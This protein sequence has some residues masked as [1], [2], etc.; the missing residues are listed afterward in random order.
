MNIRSI[1]LNVDPDNVDSSSFRYAVDLAG[2]FGAE[3]IG[4]AAEYPALPT[5]FGPDGGAVSYEIYENERQDISRRLEAAGARFRS[6]APS[7]LNP[8]WRAYLA[9]PV[10]CLVS[11]AGAV[12]LIVTGPATRTTSD[13][14]LPVDVGALVLAAGRPVIDV[15]DGAERTGIERIVIAWKDTREARR[16]VADA[17]PILM[18]AKEIF[19]ITIGEG[20][21]KVEKDSLGDLVGWLARQGVFAGAEVI[22]NG[23]LQV[24]GA[25]LARGADL[26]VSGAYGHGRVQ[27]WLFGG[28]TRSLLEAN[29]LNRLF[30]H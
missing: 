9:E 12:D 14:P 4:L 1:L 11:A 20:D 8:Q 25:A 27:Q 2:Y 22:E 6:L 26:I 30:S 18:R 16:A 10:P 7:R 5:T 19:A 3:L 29:T 17:L 13:R 21:Y 15:G 23:K 24:A 28:V